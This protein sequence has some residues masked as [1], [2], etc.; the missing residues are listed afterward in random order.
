MASSGNFVSQAFCWPRSPHIKTFLVSDA[1]VLVRDIAGDAA[2][3]AANQVNPSED[4]LAQID[5]P[6]EDNTWHDVPNLSRDNMKSQFRS[7]F[8]KQK[9]IGK[10]DAKQI[11]NNAADAANAQAN[12]TNG[13]TDQEGNVDQGAAQSAGMSAAGTATD[14]AKD[15]YNQ[16]V[17]AETREQIAN[18]KKKTMEYLRGKMPQ[19]RR[20]QTIWRLKKMVVEIQGHSD[21]EPTIPLTLSELTTVRRPASH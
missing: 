21:C 1:Q 9:P 20:E 8:D 16:N 19:E 13:V 5:R 14:Q 10:D 3:K 15:K 2:T 6:A 12:A 17:P 11:G 7:Q 18:R 4:A